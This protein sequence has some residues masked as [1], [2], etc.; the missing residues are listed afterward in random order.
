MKIIASITEHASVRRI[1]EHLQMPP[2][3]PEPLAHSPPL[4]DELLYAL[5]RPL[6]LLISS[7]AVRCRPSSKLTAGA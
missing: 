4:Q 5:R 2:Q 3:R 6:C 7:A 1:L